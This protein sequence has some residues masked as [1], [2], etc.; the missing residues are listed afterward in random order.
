MATIISSVLVM[1]KYRPL[2]MGCIEKS[3][4]KKDKKTLVI[5]AGGNHNS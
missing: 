3:V 1:G 4:G 2:D 5:F